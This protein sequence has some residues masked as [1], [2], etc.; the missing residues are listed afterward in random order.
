VFEH[1]PGPSHRT[2]RRL[3]GAPRT[4]SDPPRQDDW[5]GHS[6]GPET[7]GCQWQSRPRGEPDGTASAGRRRHRSNINTATMCIRTQQCDTLRACVA[8]PFH[9][10]LCPSVPAP[11]HPLDRPNFLMVVAAFSLKCLWLLR[12]RLLSPTKTRSGARSRQSSSQSNWLWRR[13]C[14]ARRPHAWN[15]KTVSAADCQRTAPPA[16]LWD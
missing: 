4:C 16:C 14:P 10:A 15:V 12:G 7:S 8:L 1:A 9:V 6:F 2:A 13:R 3:T 11:P 5:R